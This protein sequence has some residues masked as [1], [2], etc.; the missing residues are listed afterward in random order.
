MRH[1]EAHPVDPRAERRQADLSLPATI[2]PALAGG[3]VAVNCSHARFTANLLSA[4]P[5]GIDHLVLVGS[6]WRWSGAP[7][8]AAEQVRR[9]ESLFLASGRRGVM[10][11]PTMIYGGAQENNLQRLLRLV[12]RFPILPIPGGGTH[13][14][15]PV[16]IDDVAAAVTAAALRSWRSAEVLAV[17]GAEPLMWRTM[18]ELCAR[19]LDVRV[20]LLNLPL[21]P[22]LLILETLARLGIRPPIDPNI[23]HRFRE[24]VTLPVG[25]L[26]SA[27]GISPRSFESGLL[28]ALS[29]WRRDSGQP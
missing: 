12:R 14:V 9:A 26:R 13:M 18:A 28:D 1:P 17:P 22:L 16:H 21:A 24:D 29:A 3:R 5:E 4:L 25:P 27:L 11:H 19:A 6:A 10:L 2:G 23:L 7:E 8:A 15:Q 20:R